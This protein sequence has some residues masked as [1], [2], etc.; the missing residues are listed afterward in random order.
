MEKPKGFSHVSIIIISVII[1]SIFAFFLSSYFFVFLSPTLLALGLATTLI[2]AVWAIQAEKYDAKHNTARIGYLT[3]ILTSILS[4]N[5]F[6]CIFACTLTVPV[7]LLFL[8]FTVIFIPSYMIARSGTL[9][10]SIVGTQFTQIKVIGKEFIFLNVVLYIIVLAFTLVQGP[11][12]INGVYFMQSLIVLGV[13]FVVTYIGMETARVDYI[14]NKKIGFLILLGFLI[15]IGWCVWEMETCTGKFCEFFPF[16]IAIFCGVVM[17]VF[18]IAYWLGKRICKT[19]TATT[20]DTQTP[21]I[22]HSDLQ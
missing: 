20:V 11:G 3:A 8:T 19:Q 17:I 7:S 1:Y 4:I 15:I 16:L 13:S 2:A 5:F 18:G 22:P 10:K 9:K 12:E 14:Y 21:Q 6:S